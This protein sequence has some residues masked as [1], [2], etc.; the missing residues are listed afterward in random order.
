M[1][2]AR[3]RDP[4]V[5]RGSA[6]GAVIAGQHHGSSGAVTVIPLSSTQFGALAPVS[7]VYSRA[8]CGRRN[9]VSCVFAAICDVSGARLVAG[10]SPER[11]PLAK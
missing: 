8:T 3:S 1:L 2:P 9:C 11:L 4:D 6:R 7:V 5:V 10:F